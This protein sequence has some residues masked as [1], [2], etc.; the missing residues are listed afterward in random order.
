MHKKTP[1]IREWRKQNPERYRAIQRRAAE[2]QK[3]KQRM[4]KQEVINK[5]GGK[6]VCCAEDK[7]EFLSIDHIDN[8]GGRDRK[9]GVIYSYLA[10]QERVLDNYRVLCYNCNLSRGFY[11]YCPHETEADFV[12]FGRRPDDVRAHNKLCE[13]LKKPEQKVTL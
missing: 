7:I 11:G 2:N 8:L 12:D 5:Y 6:C 9:Y 1:Y 10:R 4:L 3:K 13:V